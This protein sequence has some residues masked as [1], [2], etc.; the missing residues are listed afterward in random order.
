MLNVYREIKRR[1]LKSKLILQVHDELIV[2]AP[3]EEKEEV[4]EI[5][6]TG[7]ESAAKLRVPLTVNVASGKN[8]YESK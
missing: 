5:L 1:N 4:S 8:W 7:M 6:R 3:E 2:D